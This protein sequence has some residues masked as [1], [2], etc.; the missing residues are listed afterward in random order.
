M[1]WMVQPGGAGLPVDPAW[2]RVYEVFLMKFVVSG[3][4][5]NGSQ[6]RGFDKE[7]EAESETRAKEIALQKLGADHHISRSRIK[8]TAVGRVDDGK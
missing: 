2:N 5:Q 8:I 7:V 3:M 4:F 1:R 6:A